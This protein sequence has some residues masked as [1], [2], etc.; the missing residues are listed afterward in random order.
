MIPTTLSLLY[1]TAMQFGIDRLIAD[2]ALRAPLADRRV[3]LLAHPASVSADLTHSLDALAALPDIQLTAAFGPQ[4]GLRGDKQDNMVESPDFADPAHGIPV[5]SLYGQVRRPTDA[6]LDTFDVV[7]IDLQDL[8][9]RIY[10]FITTLKYMLEAAAARGK[11]VWVLDRPNPAG[12]PVE[13]LTLRPGWESFVGAGPIPMRHGLT[14]GELGQWFVAQLKLDVDYRVIEMDGWAPDAAPG[15][16]WPLGER[17]WINPSPNAP[18]LWMAR[19]YAGTVMLEGAT[20]SEG[21]GTTRPLE[22]FGAPDI[23]ARAV[24]AQMRALAPHWLAGCALRDCWFEPTF[25]K[26]VG[27]LCNGV[28]IVTEGPHYDHAAFR[29]WRVQALAFKAIRR[30]WP[31]YDLWRDFP[32]EYELG[33]LPIDVI[34]GGPALREWVDD[35]AAAPADLDALTA[36]DEAAWEAERDPFLRY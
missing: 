27:Q 26:H 21:R 6:M 32:Y 17:A 19:A 31:A 20:L 4:H 28:Q 2:P 33:K 24:I 36:P 8:G 34:N 30:L 25:H 35:A 7:L 3:A 29:P 15:H 11:S 22:L 18:N 14:L 23:D 9:C 5:F 16:G 13:G 12:R 1:Q 10:T